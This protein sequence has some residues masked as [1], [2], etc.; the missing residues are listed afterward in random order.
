MITSSIVTFLSWRESQLMRN[1]VPIF[2]SYGVSQ[3]H[4]M[5]SNGLQVRDSAVRPFSSYA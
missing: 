3:S 2:S 5:V 1:F 4:V